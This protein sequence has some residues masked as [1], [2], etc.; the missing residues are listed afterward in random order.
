MAA[1]ELYDYI[2]LNMNEKANMLWDE[3]IF[4]DK[5]IDLSIITNLYYLHNFYVEVVLSN[6]NGRITEITPFK[7]GERLD[8]YL[9]HVDLKE[10]I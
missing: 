7:K 2:K 1:V 5:Y 9:G 4:I 3:G 10:L 8:K 6:S